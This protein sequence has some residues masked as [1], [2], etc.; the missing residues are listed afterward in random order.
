MDPGTKLLPLTVM[1]ND[2]LPTL[3][4]LGDILVVLGIGLSALATEDNPNVAPTIP[5]ATISEIIIFLLF[6]GVICL[7]FYNTVRPLYYV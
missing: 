7:F 3:A 1:I 4:K 5:K 6:I 2:E